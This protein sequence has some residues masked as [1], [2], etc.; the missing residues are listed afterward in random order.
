MRNKDEIKF[1]HSPHKYLKDFLNL[2]DV[3]IINGS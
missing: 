2:L 1:C 3:K